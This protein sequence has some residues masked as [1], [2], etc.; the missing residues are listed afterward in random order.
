MKGLDD[1]EREALHSLMTCE[2]VYEIQTDE[3][4]WARD[5][6]VKRGL[7]IAYDDLDEDGDE[8]TFWEPTPLGELIYRCLT[9]QAA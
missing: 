6:L 2:Y 3:E 5:R 4:K 8:C 7:A 9:E 1:M